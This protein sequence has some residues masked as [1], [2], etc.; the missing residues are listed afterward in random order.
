MKIGG[1]EVLE[2]GRLRQSQVLAFDFDM[3]TRSVAV[4]VAQD[5]IEQVIADFEEGGNGHH[6]RV[7]LK[8]FTE[9]NMLVFAEFVKAPGTGQQM[10]ICVD[11]KCSVH[12]YVLA[13]LQRPR[14]ELTQAEKT[15]FRRNLVQPARSFNLLEGCKV[16]DYH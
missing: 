3:R 13:D 15:Q 14:L 4:V 12:V 11:I 9:E 16:T 8:Q 1:R 5:L 2:V 7:T 6:Q 10:L